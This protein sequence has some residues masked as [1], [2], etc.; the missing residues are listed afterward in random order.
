LKIDDWRLKMADL[1]YWGCR[2]LGFIGFL[3][4]KIVREIEIEIEIEVE[5]EVEIK[6]ESKSEIASGNERE[7]LI[8]IFGW[9]NVELRIEDWG[10]WVE[11]WGFWVEGWGLRVSSWG[12]RVLSWGLRGFGFGLGFRV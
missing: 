6:S 7:M 5:I 9:R 3:E 10:F 8:D 11:G 4:L 2:G 1:L 12:L